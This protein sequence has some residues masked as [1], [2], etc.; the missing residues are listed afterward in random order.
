MN[1]PKIVF[2]GGGSVSWGPNLLSDILHKP[3]LAEAAL[4]LVDHDLEAAE[5][6][7]RFVHKIAAERKLGPR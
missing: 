6:T 2:V 3:A 5:L 4:V 7:E 1:A